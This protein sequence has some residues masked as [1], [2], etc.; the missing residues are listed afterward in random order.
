MR[1]IALLQA[2]ESEG[3]PKLIRGD[4]HVQ[5]R[6]EAWSAPWNE[7]GKIGTILGR[8]IDARTANRSA[9]RNRRPLASK[10]TVSVRSG[11][12]VE[13]L[14]STYN[15]AAYLP[16]FLESLEAQDCDAWRLTARDDGSRD[17]TLSILKT[18]CNRFPDRARVLDGERA[19]NLGLIRSFSRLIEESSA[20]YVMF[21]DQ[22]DIWLPSKVRITLE[23]MRAKQDELGKQSPILLHTD[24]KLVDKDLQIINSSLWKSQ[25]VRPSAPSFPKIL[26]ENVAWGCTTMINRQLVSLVGSI[27]KEAVYHDWWVTLTAAAFGHVVAISAPTILYRRHGLNESAISNLA[28]VFKAAL[29]DPI[30]ARQRLT[31][32]L[33]GS[34]PRV[35]AFLHRHR[36]RLTPSQIAAADAF[37]SLGDANFVSRRVHIARHG[38]LFSSSLRN[39]GLFVLL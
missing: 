10:R 8:R 17:A 23:K 5:T 21:A 36:T 20:S 38:L 31:E 33:A 7:T 34:R 35:V 15:G 1:Q 2:Q 32:V 28:S 12:D 13:I 30:A 19:P 14:L 9:R 26:V 11:D 29:R 4:V 37:L 22:D 39:I 25:G 16:A 6:G 27:P 24:L 18:W 3:R